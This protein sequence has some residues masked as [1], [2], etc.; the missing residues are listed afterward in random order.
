MKKSIFVAFLM[1]FFTM[2]S[3]SAQKVVFPT[4]DKGR[5]RYTNEYETD[6]TKAELF[7]SVCLWPVTTFHASD[8][9][10]SKDEAKGEV[11]ANGTVKSKSAYNPFAGSFNEYVTFVVKFVVDE[12]KISYT[13]YRPT[14]TETYAGYGT[15]SKSTNMDDIYANYVQAYA[16]IEAAKN[17]PT[18]SKKDAKAIIKEAESVIKDVEESLEEAE[19]AMRNVTKMLESNLF[20]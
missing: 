19:E 4:D 7:E 1:L 14:L 13:L 20:R 15:N 8:A 3:I 10:F 6:Q 2:G 11:L 18:L 16:N 12:G 5:I 17:D 9:V